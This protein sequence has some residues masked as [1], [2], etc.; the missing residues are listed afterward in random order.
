M[1]NEKTIGFIGESKFAYEYIYKHLESRK[2][3]R[4]FD[5]YKDLYKEYYNIFSNNQ[6]IEF[7]VNPNI[8]LHHAIRFFD[9]IDKLEF[10]MSV[11]KVL[12]GEKIPNYRN[13]LMN[14]NEGKYISHL[15]YNQ[16]DNTEYNS[17]I[18]RNICLMVNPII[19]PLQAIYVNSYMFKYIATNY[20]EHKNRYAWAH[21][22]FHSEEF[23]FSYVDS[24]GVPF[25]YFNQCYGED[26]ADSELE[27]VISLLEKYGYNI[28]IY[29]NSTGNFEVLHE[30]SKVLSKSR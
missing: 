18:K 6:S 12:P 29:D 19:N 15:S 4:F 20:K 21:D 28:P 14:S 7:K 11:G 5:I 25:A 10:F 26:F 9:A 8:H 13:E 17:F 22:E 3:L 24:I 1:F 30:R 23:S 16:N 27:K 2:Q